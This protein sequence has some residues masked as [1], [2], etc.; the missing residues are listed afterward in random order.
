MQIKILKPTKYFYVSELMS[1]F[2]QVLVTPMQPVQIFKDHMSV[3]ANQDIKVNQIFFA[4]DI[5]ECVSASTCHSSATCLNLY[6]EH[7]SVN[8]NQDIDVNQI[9]VFMFQILMSVLQQV[10]VT[11]IQLDL[12]FQDNMSVNANHYTE[13]NQIFL[14]SDIDECASAST[15]HSNATCLNPQGSYECKCKSGY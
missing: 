5:D 7:M 6:K 10:L 4:S 11:P 8:A 14:I 3:N 15:C 9:Y 2:Q 13:V 1:V 12:I